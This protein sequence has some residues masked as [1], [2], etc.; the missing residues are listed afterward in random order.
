MLAI[1]S[2]DPLNSAAFEFVAGTLR[3]A[4]RE[5][6]KKILRNN[7]DL[8]QEVHFWEEHFMAL[9]APTPLPPAADS[10]AKIQ[11]RLAGVSTRGEPLTPRPWWQHIRQW[12]LPSLVA[13]V[14]TLLLVL[15]LPRFFV[16][17]FMQPSSDYVAIMADTQGRAALTAFTQG[18]H[19]AMRLQWQQ[20]AIPAGKNIQLWAVSK[21]DKQARALAVFA[22]LV[23][24][25]PLNG[26]QQRLVQDAEYLLLTEEDL[27]GSPLDEP[28]EIIVAKGLCVRLTA[29]ESVL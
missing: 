7:P 17:S 13:S 4:D 19:A 15:T 27:G 22:N 5:A 28:S 6:F 18:Q 16:Q 20:V 3:G 25:L 23:D 8:Q 21:R 12:W 24:H 11:P 10:W 26:A 29:N 1:P 9:P 2:S 14:C